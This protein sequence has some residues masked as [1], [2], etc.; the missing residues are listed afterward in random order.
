ML[1]HLFVSQPG[2]LVCLRVLHIAFAEFP[3]GDLDRTLINPR[4]ISDLRKLAGLRHRARLE[5]CE[6]SWTRF[7]FDRNKSIQPLSL[8]CRFPLRLAF[9]PLPAARVFYART[10]HIQLGFLA[11]FDSIRT[12]EIFEIGTVEAQCPPDF[13]ERQFSLPSPAIDSRYRD[14]QKFSGISY[15]H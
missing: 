8:F 2:P 7:G 9:Y 14:R 5:L 4:R 13:Y 1:E 10:R 15:C 6:D 12:N 11:R 3:E